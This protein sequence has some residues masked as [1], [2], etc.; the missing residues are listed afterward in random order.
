MAAI[1]TGPEPG[2]RARPIAPGGLRVAIPG[3]SFGDIPVLGS[4]ALDVRPGETVA[5]LGPSGVGKTTLLRVAAGLAPVGGT[6]ERPERI[7]M[8]FQEPNLL[9]W[10]TAR[11]NV[12][13]LAGVDEGAAEAALA[14]VGVA[15]RGDAFPRQLSLGQQRRLALARAFAARPSLVLLDEPFASLDEATRDGML[16]LTARLLRESGAAALL[17][18]HSRAE[19]AI[20][21]RVQVLEG[22]PAT[23]RNADQ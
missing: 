1:V 21:D 2:A 9:P 18:T 11:A 5:L 22:R 19:A 20:A 6:V 15:G 23:L 13:L 17:V 3:L 10:R 8:V 4:I 12:A 14:S 7:A 16:A